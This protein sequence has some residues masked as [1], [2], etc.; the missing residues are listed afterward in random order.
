MKD[1]P[2]IYWLQL[3]NSH[4]IKTVK[5][6]L[7]LS[8]ASLLLKQHVPTATCPP[9]IPATPEDY[10]YIMHCSGDMA[11]QKGPQGKRASCGAFISPIACWNSHHPSCLLPRTWTLI[12]CCFVTLWSW[13][14][15]VPSTLLRKQSEN[16]LKKWVWKCFSKPL[17]IVQ[18]LT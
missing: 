18:Q 5:L 8:N 10:L 1:I 3:Y 2:T 15:R 16:C 9:D 12:S 17:D 11:L 14:V 13:S 4:I 6:S 7:A